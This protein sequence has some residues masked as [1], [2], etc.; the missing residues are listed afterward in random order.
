V[1]MEPPVSFDADAIRDEKMKV[2]RSVR[3]LSPEDAAQ[4]TVRG[5]YQG[6]RGEAQVAPDSQTPTFAAMRLFIDNWRWQG[7]PFYLRAGK[8]MAERLTHIVIQFRSVPVCLFGDDAICRL[9][10]PNVLALRIQPL[11][12]INLSFMVKPPGMQLDIRPE[13]LNFCYYCRYGE[14]FDAYERLLLNLLQGDQTLF[15]R[16][17][18]V[19]AQWRIVQPILEYWDSHPAANF[20]NYATGSWGPKE[21]DALINRDGYS[22]RNDDVEAQTTHTGCRSPGSRGRR[23]NRRATGQ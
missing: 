4:E 17:D 21:A 3:L 13:E 10:N 6:Y 15:V 14:G 20:P 18:A 2:L 19:E 22:W 12:S 16:S 5:Q 8:S 7:V 11:E 23:V 9:L 1:G